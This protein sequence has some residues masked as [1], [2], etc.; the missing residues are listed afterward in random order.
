MAEAERL[1]LARE[2]GL[3]GG[4]KIG[5]ELCEL[6]FLAAPLERRVELELLVEMVLDRAFVA[7]RH[8]DEVLDAG[9][10]RL[11]DHVLDDRPVDHRQHLLRDRLGG[12]QEPGAETGDGK[13]GFADRLHGISLRCRGN[14][15]IAEG[16]PLSYRKPPASPMRAGIP[17]N[18][19]SGIQDRRDG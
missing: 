8:E 11:V 14:Q 3:A 16:R 10:A 15:G 5:L 13:H 1:L 7:P 18:A 17:A 2:A 4:R 19:S 9:R 12:R 6:L